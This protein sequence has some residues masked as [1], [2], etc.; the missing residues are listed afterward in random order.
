M[1]S[2]PTRSLL[3]VFPST[4]SCTSCVNPNA[5]DPTDNVHSVCCSTYGPCTLPVDT[6]PLDALSNPLTS[7]SILAEQTS[8]AH[9]SKSDAQ[10][11]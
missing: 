10:P 6:S 8:Q 1:S 4:E 3:A 5:A 9:G 2:G 7:A 11:M